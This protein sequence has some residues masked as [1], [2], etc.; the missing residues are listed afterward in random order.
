MINKRGR[1]RMMAAFRARCVPQVDHYYYVLLLLR[2]SNLIII[3]LLLLQSLLSLQRAIP[4][5]NDTIA[6][7]PQMAARH[8]IKAASLE[9]F[10]GPPTT[11]GARALTLYPSLPYYIIS[12][13]C[14]ALLC[15]LL[16]SLLSTS[17]YNC[18]DLL[19]SPNL[20]YPTLPHPII[21]IRHTL[22][23]VP[24]AKHQCV[25]TAVHIEITIVIHRVV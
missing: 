20:S 9:V 23:N 6:F 11:M 13:P 7:G 1:A 17:T 24:Y 25:H 22:H 16:C 8:A 12:L 18:Y 19:C 15:C 10:D 14:P 5:R 21:Y 2:L 4:W 3:L